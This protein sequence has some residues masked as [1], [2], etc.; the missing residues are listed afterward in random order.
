MAIE[1]KFAGLGVASSFAPNPNLQSFQSR[2]SRTS[3][4]HHHEII[5]YLSEKSARICADPSALASSTPATNPEPLI[6]SG[7]L[8]AR[9]GG[10]VHAAPDPKPFGLDTLLVDAAP[11]AKTVTLGTAD[12][13]AG[14]DAAITPGESFHDL[15]ISSV[16]L[17][18]NTATGGWCKDLSLI[19]ENWDKQPKSR[20]P[21]F[22]LTPAVNAVATIATLDNYYPAGAM[23]YPWASYRT[24]DKERF[25][26]I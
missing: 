3:C 24:K 13:L 6:S 11:A 14:E 4:T 7:T 20:L 1:E 19:T 25:Y 17:L 2:P 18:T 8:G 10:E 9:S 21:F 15:S 23:L 26:P 16:G 12:L 5:P 22:R